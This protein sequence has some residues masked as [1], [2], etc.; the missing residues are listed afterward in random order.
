MYFY[1]FIVCVNTRT[2]RIN[3]NVFFDVTFRYY[4]RS[5]TL[6]ILSYFSGSNF[7]ELLKTCF[8]N[9]QIED[10]WIRF[11]CV[12]TNVTD[13]RCEVHEVGPLWRY[14]T[15]VHRYML[16]VVVGGRCW[17]S[18]LVV[19]VGGGC[20]WWMLVVDVGGGCWWSMLVVDVGGGCWW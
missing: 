5:L 12:T 14:V 3:T 2:S 20:W 1:M 15:P 19:D 7:N 6:P 13:R 16:V 11:F 18:M 8:G 10:L 17:W 4:L 9:A